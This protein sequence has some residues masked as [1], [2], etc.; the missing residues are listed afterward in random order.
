MRIKTALASLVLMMAFLCQASGSAQAGPP[1]QLR[2]L[3]VNQQNAALPHATVTVYTL[4]GKPGVT[5]TADDK[6]IALFPSIATGL[7]QIVAKSS[8]LAPYIDKTT[9][10]SGM[11]TQTVVLRAPGRRES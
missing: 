9:V 5:V 8:G 2:L 6:G 11:N 10:K 7:A 4:D 3:L 1:A